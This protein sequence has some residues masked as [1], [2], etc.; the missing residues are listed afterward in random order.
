MSADPTIEA[1]PVGSISDD[2]AAAVLLKRPPRTG[3]DLLLSRPESGVIIAAFLTANTPMITEGLGCGSV[4]DTQYLFSSDVLGTNTG[5]YPPHS[6]KYADFAR[7]LQRLQTLRIQAIRAF[8]E[9][10]R[11]KVYPEPQHE[12]D[13]D[14]ETFSEFLSHVSNLS[15]PN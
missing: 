14:E 6:K 15:N 1:L 2:D 11:G 4:C 9:D 10:V 13:I 8:V 5:H 7:E 12:I 3:L